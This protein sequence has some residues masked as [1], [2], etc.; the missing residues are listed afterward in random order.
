M[1]ARTVVSFDDVVEA[2]RSL[3]SEGSAVTGW[4]LRRV[5]GRGDPARLIS[6]WQVH[7]SE[8]VQ[9]NEAPLESL[10]P[11][12]P[13]V[14][15]SIDAM[16]ARVGELAVELWRVADFISV[17]RVQG[18]A[19]AV[20]RE[21][22]TLRDELDQA[23]VALAAADQ[24][25]EVAEVEVERLELVASEAVQAAA[26]AEQRAKLAEALAEAVRHDLRESLTAKRAN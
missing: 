8:R 13:V 2:G 6:L 4:A 12:P 14:V 25:R 16:K 5:V 1:S 20:R 11:V 10:L 24:A 17:Q 23:S 22:N 19:D 9:P 7:Q 15:K 3:A 26:E 21:L 18:E